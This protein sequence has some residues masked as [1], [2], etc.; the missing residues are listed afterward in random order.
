LILLVQCKTTPKHT[1]TLLVVFALVEGRVTGNVLLLLVVLIPRAGAWG[2]INFEAERAKLQQENFNLKHGLSL[3]QDQLR[4]RAG[5]AEGAR[6]MD[7]NLQLAGQLREFEIEN[8]ALRSDA[9]AK[10]V[11]PAMVPNATTLRARRGTTATT[12]LLLLLLLLPAHWATME[13]RSV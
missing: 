12:M 4:S 2:T 5:S 1:V 10:A 8:N 9:E 7:D 11:P 13:S 6:I 3:L